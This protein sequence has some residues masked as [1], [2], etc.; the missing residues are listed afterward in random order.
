MIDRNTA[1]IRLTRRYNEQLAAIP[2]MIEIPIERYITANI[3]AVQ[4]G[5]LLK[6]YDRA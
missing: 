5:D 1:A 4:D 3:V 2:T 6:Q